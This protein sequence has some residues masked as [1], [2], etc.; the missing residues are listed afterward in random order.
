MKATNYNK[1]GE[2]IFG[3]WVM[4][5]IGLAAFIVLFAKLYYMM[6]PG[7]GLLAGCNVVTRPSA[8]SSKEELSQVQRTTGKNMVRVSALVFSGRSLT[9]QSSAAAGGSKR[10]K[11]SKLFHKIKRARHDDQRLAPAAG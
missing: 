9:R 4:V 7:C 8:K 11:L 5:A 1:D 2:A 6:C 3:V 10:G